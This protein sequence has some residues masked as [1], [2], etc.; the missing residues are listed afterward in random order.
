[1]G[2]RPWKAGQAKFLRT[3]LQSSDICQR[4]QHDVWQQVPNDLIDNE[5]TL[6]DFPQEGNNIV[7]SSIIINIRSSSDGCI[8]DQI[9]THC[10]LLMTDGY[11]RSMNETTRNESLVERRERRDSG[12]E[13]TLTNLNLPVKLRQTKT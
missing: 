10:I 9:E 12:R 2:D 3:W 6:Q 7:I 8:L 5:E 11:I 1:M 13:A 4:K